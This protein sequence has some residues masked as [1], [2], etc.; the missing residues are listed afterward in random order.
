MSFDRYAERLPELIAEAP[1]DAGYPDSV[2]ATFSL[3]I[4]KAAA[5]CAEAE[6]LIAL[7]AFFAPDKI[8]LLLIREDVLSEKQ[9]EKAL[10]ALT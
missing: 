4:E 2:F 9:R 5:D 1:K 3:A 8:P 10:A 6:A 7:L